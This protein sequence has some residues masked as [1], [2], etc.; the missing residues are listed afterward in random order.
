[1]RSVEERE[2]RFKE[3][4]QEISRLFNESRRDPG[5]VLRVEPDQWK[6][7]GALGVKGVSADWCRA[8]SSELLDR[9]S[10]AFLAR[11]WFDGYQA[12]YKRSGAD[13]C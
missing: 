4:V 12:E 2:Q 1:M 6:I 8:Y 13:E 11:T 10:P 9:E 3:L 7:C 5:A